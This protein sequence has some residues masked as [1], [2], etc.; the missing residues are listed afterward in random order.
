[1]RTPLLAVLLVVA[2][3]GQPATTAAS[4][5]PQTS[6]PA[7]APSSTPQP[8]DNVPDEPELSKKELR[9]LTALAKA[10]GEKDVQSL[11]AYSYVDDGYI[12]CGRGD[13]GPPTVDLIVE[14]L[15]EDGD[16]YAA[17]IKHLCPK[18][19]P[20][21]R[22]AAGGFTDGVYTVGKDIRAGTYRTT[23][24]RLTKCY[25]ERSTGAGRIIDNQWVTNAPNGATVSVRRGEGFTSEGCG[26][27]IRA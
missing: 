22:K 9:Y 23:P 26:N 21:W 25:W 7:P 19:L 14:N 24:G 13:E 8:T 27:W 1:M 2:G 12:V 20:V 3:C 15:E 4:T 17:A 5:P 11:T 16:M 18:Y 10:M 6:T